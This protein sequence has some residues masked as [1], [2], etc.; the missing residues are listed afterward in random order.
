M[1]KLIVLNDDI[2]FVKNLCNHIFSEI[3]ELQLCGFTSDFAEFEKLVAKVKPYIIMMN[4]SDYIHSQYTKKSDFLKMKIL[5]CNTNPSSKKSP[6]QLLTSKNANLNEM[7]SLIKDFVSKEHIRLLREKIIK[8]LE[9]FQFDFKLIGTTYVLESILYCY[10]NKTDYVFENLEKN[11]YPNVAI[12]CN[13]NADNVKWSI[14][15]S[16]NAMNARIHMPISKQLSSQ[17][18]L[19]TTEKTT[20]KQLISAIV[21]KLS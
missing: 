20:A 9:N 14:V 3:P 17:L 11:V 21:T 15:R 12:I 4:Y 2:E 8:L 1:F 6:K 16:I 5:F 10:E 19:D 13:T 18:N 7:K